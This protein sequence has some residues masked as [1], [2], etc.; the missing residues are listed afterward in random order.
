MGSRRRRWG[1]HH[2]RGGA[3]LLATGA[4]NITATTLTI[5]GTG[6]HNAGT[7]VLD[8]NAGVRAASFILGSNATIGVTHGNSSIQ[9]PIGDGGN[10]YGVTLVGGG[11]LTF[12]ATNTYTGTTIIDRGNLLIDGNSSSSSVF[13]VD[14]GGSLIGDVS[15]EARPSPA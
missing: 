1:Q 11:T 6:V 5:N 12:T 7:L 9:V 3:E 15:V 8:N 10:Y 14:S 4:I 2:G 13:T